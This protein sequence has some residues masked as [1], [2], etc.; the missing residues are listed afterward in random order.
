[1]F[2]WSAPNLLRW[3][4]ALLVCNFANHCRAEIISIAASRDNT[5]YQSTDTATQR[6]N[7]AGPLTA[8]RTNQDGSG[9]ATISIRRGLIFFDIATA[10]S[11]PSIINSVSLSMTETMGNNGDRSVALHRAN[12]DWGQGTSFSVGGQGSAA[13]Q[14]DATW[15]YRFFEPAAPVASPAWNSAGGDFDPI[16]SA[17]TLVVDD[18]GIDQIFTWQSAA[19]AGDVQ[20]WLDNP[21]ANFGWFIIGDETVGRSSKQFSSSES[22]GGPTLLIEYTPVAIPEPESLLLIAI[23]VGFWVSLRSH[24]CCREAADV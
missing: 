12:A 11:Q 3:H 6:S 16:A 9:P 13:T 2:F 20:M 19:L 17:S 22:I 23:S 18:F 24:L 4:V 15:L 7:A 10:I 14:N 8:G 21:S 5:L 1:M